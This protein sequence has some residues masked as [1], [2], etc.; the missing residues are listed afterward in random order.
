MPI[1]NE[2]SVQQDHLLAEAA[3]IYQAGDLDK[4][5]TI[6]KSLLAGQGLKA[7]VT[8]KSVP[9]QTVSLTSFNQ[10]IEINLSSQTLDA[11]ALFSGLSPNTTY[12]SRVQAVNDAG[13]A[14]IAELTNLELLN[15]F[16]TDVRDDGMNSVQKLKKLIREAEA[17]QHIKPE[18]GDGCVARVNCDMSFG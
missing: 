15:V 7:S 9:F 1:R 4:A 14:I 6:A 10:L 11:S 13:L 12:Y 8:L 2:N 17:G 18:I 5:E 3:A 16:K